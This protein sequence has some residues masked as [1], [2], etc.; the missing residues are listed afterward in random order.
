MW[1]LKPRGKDQHNTLD[2]I[3]CEDTYFQQLVG[4]WLKTCI[5]APQQIHKLPKDRLH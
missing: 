1:F 2:A 5:L 3:D 4:D